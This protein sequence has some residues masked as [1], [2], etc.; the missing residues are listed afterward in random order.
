MVYDNLSENTK[1]IRI[2]RWPE[3]QSRVGSLNPM[4]MS[5]SQKDYSQNLL[6]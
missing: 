3:V 1:P 6:D 4:L 2:L 5:C